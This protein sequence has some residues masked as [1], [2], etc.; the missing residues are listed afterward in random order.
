MWDVVEKALDVHVYRPTVFVTA[1]FAFGHCTVRRFVRP[2]TI[3][4]GME[5]LSSYTALARQ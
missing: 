4:V 5:H 2:V 1:F 3:A